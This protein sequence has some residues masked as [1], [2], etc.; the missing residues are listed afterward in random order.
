MCPVCISTI[1]LT[2]AGAT[3]TGGVTAFV[4]KKF[5]PKGGTNKTRQNPDQ[6]ADSL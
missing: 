3:S 4:V 1:A 5:L 6:K 2:V